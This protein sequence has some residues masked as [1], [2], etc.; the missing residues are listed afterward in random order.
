MSIKSASGDLIE[1]YPSALGGSSSC[2]KFC[3]SERSSPNRRCPD[4]R[5]QFVHGPVSHRLCS[6]SCLPSPGYVGVG[7]SNANQSVTGFTG[8]VPAPGG[9]LFGPGYGGFGI[10][11][12]NRSVNFRFHIQLQV[13]HCVHQV[14]LW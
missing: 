3:M 10:S 6:G 13:R 2:L 7:I 1:S 5:Q 12:V 9:C 11:N 8:C 14:S 4:P